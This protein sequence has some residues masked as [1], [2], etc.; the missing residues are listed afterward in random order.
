MIHDT[1]RRSRAGTS[2][3]KRRKLTAEVAVDAAVARLGGA[4]AGM[5][6]VLLDGNAKAMIDK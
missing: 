2:T 4:E 3:G 5:A 1:H 6:G